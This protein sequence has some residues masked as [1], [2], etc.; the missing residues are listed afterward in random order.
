MRGFAV[1]SVVLLALAVST[2]C[3]ANP[4]PSLVGPTGLIT[5]PNTEV[6]GQNAVDVGAHFYSIDGTDARIWHANVGLCDQVELTVAWGVLDE[7]SFEFEDTTFGVKWAAL[8]EPDDDIGL[9]VG[10][11]NIGAKET[12]WFL[13]ADGRSEIT[14]IDDVDGP[15]WYF[16]L[17]KSLHDLS[18]EG[19]RPIRVLAGLELADDAY[20]PTGIKANA[21]G[22]NRWDTGFG[23]DS[24]NFFVGLDAEVAD[25]L[26]LVIDTNEFDDFN[27]GGRFNVT[28]EWSVDLLGLDFWGETTRFVVGTAYHV[29]WD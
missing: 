10:V 29:T 1:A 19:K 25:W 14:D 13:E 18:L 6:V 27:W 24:P 9:A 17:S 16:V 20:G 12:T 7:N 8:A 2:L 22:Y 23:D 26:T 28:D 15:I 21:L 5:V 4:A 11:Y 3:G